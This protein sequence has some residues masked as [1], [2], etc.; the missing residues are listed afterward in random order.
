MQEAI[1]AEW[2]I[3]LTCWGKRRSRDLGSNVPALCYPNNSTEF[4][5]M[6]MYRNIYRCIYRYIYTAFPQ[7]TGE[8]LQVLPAAFFSPLAVLTPIWREITKC[9]TDF[10]DEKCFRAA[11]SIVICAL[12]AR[13]ERLSRKQIIMSYNRKCRL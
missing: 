4:H 8:E 5:S 10:F 2:K 9:S 1:S 6:Y 11:K 3:S 12:K 13:W 7:A